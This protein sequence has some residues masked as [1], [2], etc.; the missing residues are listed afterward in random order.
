MKRII[1]MLLIT[2]LMTSETVV[3]A[4]SL[5]YSSDPTVSKNS[6]TVEQSEEEIDYEGV[7]S[8]GQ[9]S[10]V[11]VIFLTGVRILLSLIVMI[12]VIGLFVVYYDYHNDWYTHALKKITRGAC[13]SSPRIAITFFIALGIHVI[14]IVKLWDGKLFQLVI[15]KYLGI[16]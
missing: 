16:I 11:F 8:S 12:W 2:L 4:Y 15:S 3:S 1:L 9:S 5:G 10:L 13:D 6:S 7:Y 14:L